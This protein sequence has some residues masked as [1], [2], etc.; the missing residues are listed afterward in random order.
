MTDSIISLRV[1]K[2]ILKK[3][4]INNEINWS[5]FIRNCLN[6]RLEKIQETENNFDVEKARRASEGIDRIRNS[7][8]FDGGKSSVELIREWRDKRK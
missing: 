8:I 5:A 6:Q 2:E 7:K 4:R 3:M 1:D